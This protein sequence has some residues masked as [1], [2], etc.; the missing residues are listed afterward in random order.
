MESQQTTA[1]IN[2][3]GNLPPGPKGVPILGNALQLGREDIL[4]TYLDMYRQYGDI[5]YLKLGPLDGYVLFNPEHVH[6]VLVK[7]QKNYI[8]G[9]GYDGFRLLV[10]QGLVTSDGE[11]WRQQRRLMG[12][13]FTP[14]AITQFSDMMVKITHEMLEDWGTI[15]DRG[16]TLVMDDHM[17]RLTMSIIGRAMFS[18]DLSEEMT[19]IGRAFEE[20]FGFIPTR[21]NAILPLSLPLPAHRR[22]QKNLEII[23]EF[24]A[25]QIQAGRENGGQ[26]NLLGILL[27]AKDEETGLEMSETQLRD[28][29]VTLFFAGFETTARSLTWGWY[30]LAKHP[31]VMRKM[32]AEVDP[33]IGMRFPQIDDLYNLHYTRMVVDETLRL[34]PPTALLAR[35]N[36]EE[37]EIGGYHIPP[38]SMIILV[39][40][41]VHRY[42]GMW[43]DPEQFDPERFTQQASQER[44]KSAYVPFAAGPR[45]CLGNNFALMEMVY[46]FSM[47][48]ARFRVEMVSDEDI[49]YEFAGTIRPTR[50][51]LVK[52]HNR[53]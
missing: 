46:A 37:D 11:L 35:Q 29:V 39:P 24:I 48:A 33:V 16:E 42:P 31:E 25:Q 40:Y 3:N 7:N 6:H 1:E 52:V 17:L 41:V 45:V 27:Q 28:E 32:E 44:P 51:L 4:D 36:V 12:P 30:L 8:K 26:D 50:P 34:Y 43:S 9:I 23:D 53:H 21:T 5:V 47:A 18:I 20:A 19:E 22:F 38:Q 15:A 49:P 2:E 10:G 13:Y 14:K